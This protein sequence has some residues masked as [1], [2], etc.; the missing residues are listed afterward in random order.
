L[1]QT[2]AG[3]KKHEPQVVKLLQ[4]RRKVRQEALNQDLG[5]R[6][7]GCPQ[8]GRS[9]SKPCACQIGF[10]L[11]VLYGLPT[12]ALACAKVL[13]HFTAGKGS[14]EKCPATCKAMVL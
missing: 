5:P 2:A 7:K 13:L 6:G 10:L 4:R 1:L 12:G 8:L 14:P 3:N 11:A 9:S